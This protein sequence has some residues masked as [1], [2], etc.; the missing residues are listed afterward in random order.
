MLLCLG[1][2][3]VFASDWYVRPAEGEYGAEDGSA[4][5]AAF[6]GFADIDWG[7][8]YVQAGDTLH[9]CGYFDLDSIDDG[10]LPMFQIDA[11]GTGESARI[12]IDGNCAAFGDLSQ[13]VLSGQGIRARGVDSGQTQ[14][15]YV[16]LRNLFILYFTSKGVYAQ[17]SSTG[18]AAWRLENID[19]AEIRGST[20]D[21]FDLRGAGHYVDENSSATNIGEDAWYVEGDNFTIKAA[22]NFPSLDGMTGDCLQINQEADNF[23]ISGFR[24]R[25]SV[26][27]KQCVFVSAS[28]ATGSGVL[29]DSRCYG[30]SVSSG[31]HTCFLFKDLNGGVVAM[32]NYAKN[33]RYLLYVGG[34]G[35]TMMA[36]SN[37]G[38]GLSS[39]GIQCGT[40]TLACSLYN[41][42]VAA[43]PVCY[44]TAAA[45][46]T[47]RLQNNLGYGC[48]TAMMRKN[49]GDIELDNAMFDS[50]NFVQNEAVTITPDASDITVDPQLVSTPPNAASDFRLQAT[51]PLRS[52]GGCY[53]SNGC[54]FVDYRGMVARMPPDIGAYQQQ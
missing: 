33:S 30:P 24:C 46:S 10:T 14:R 25:H 45:S 20:A 21:G 50:A 36:V 22:C 16:T 32:R 34:T 31:Q 43:T 38:V 28:G 26:D 27:T 2:F 41:N 1:S 40:G 3:Q 18:I 8:P 17:G 29:T 48:T 37:I 7:A 44:S 53:L 4:Y 49:V 6:D 15:S 11:S 42:A 51:S 52:A 35:T 39:G 19:V 9:V 54:S 23:L 13:A 47:S 5:A 12:V